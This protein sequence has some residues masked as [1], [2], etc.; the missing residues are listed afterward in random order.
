[1]QPC[2]F[3]VNG[4]VISIES[5][6]DSIVSMM[7]S[8]PFGVELK[9]GEQRQPDISFRVVEAASAP[10][11]PKRGSFQN[12]E[13]QFVAHDKYLVVSYLR[14]KPW[15]VEV[16]AYE[17]S[18]ADLCFCLFEPLMCTYLL[19]LGQLQWHCSGVTAGGKS[20][21]IPGDS[22]SGKS[23]TALTL[24]QSGFDFLADESV[25]LI[26]ADGRIDAASFDQDLYLRRSSVERLLQLEVVRRAPWITRGD[27]VKKR[28]KLPTSKARLNT[29]PFPV[30]LVLFP[31]LEDRKETVLQSLSRSEAL[32]Q[33]MALAAKNPIVI[34]R[35][36][37]ALNR[38]LEIYTT[39][40]TTSRCY[41]IL[42]GSDLARV[43]DAVKKEFELG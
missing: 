33:C 21:L 3:D 24:A 1:M 9:R 2:C 11:P 14:G 23:T 29:G 27:E 17:F 22:G 5:N 7:R 16:T 6:T 39:I 15:R 10:Y 25:F 42:L 41:R 12:D 30:E 32:M 20:I 26:L 38:Q 19:R 36:R 13:L 4:T 43:A 8:H 31:S 28:I 34:F 37:P 18:A 35:D 40:A